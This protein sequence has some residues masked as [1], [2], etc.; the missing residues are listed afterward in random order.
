MALLTRSAPVYALAWQLC[1]IQGGG[2]AASSCQMLSSEQWAHLDADNGAAWLAV[3]AQARARSD[4]AGEMQALFRLAQAHR[5]NH[6]WDAAAE[7]VLNYVPQQLSAEHALAISAQLQRLGRSA[8]VQ[9]HSIALQHCAQEAQ[10]NAN[11][12]QECAGIAST[13]STHA[14]SLAEL[15][16]AI[17]LGEQGALP[18]LQVQAL[19]QEHVA[20]SEALAQHAKRSNSAPS[21]CADVA[22]E[23]DHARLLAQ[24][25]ELRLARA[26]M[27]NA[28]AK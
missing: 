11:R 26:Q 3:A 15:K 14:R 28:V 6:Y 4:I 7:L 1:Q 10:K 5:L 2:D 24:H 19:S 21:A 18:A 25:G 22:R 17:G 27:L 23:L 16:T 20:L 8:S 9:A 12:Q 13:I